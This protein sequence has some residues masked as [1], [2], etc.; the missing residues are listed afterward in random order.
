MAMKAG[1]DLMANKQAALDAAKKGKQAV[2]NF[3]KGPAVTNAVASISQS[4]TKVA[5]SAS[6][7]LKK[8]KFG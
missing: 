3:A 7:A 2:M 8:I 5:N 4:G 1:K 6:N